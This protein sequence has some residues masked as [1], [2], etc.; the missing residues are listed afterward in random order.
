MK[1]KNIILIIAGVVSFI[2]T[3]VVVNRMVRDNR[4]KVDPQTD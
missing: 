1:K 3:C 2:I 4:N